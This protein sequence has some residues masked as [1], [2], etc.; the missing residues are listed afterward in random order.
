[1][2]ELPIDGQTLLVV[3]IGILVVIWLFGLVRRIGGCLINLILLAAAGLALYGI[4]T[5][6]ITLPF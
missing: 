1:M 4:A 2:E 6:M 5:G 3:G